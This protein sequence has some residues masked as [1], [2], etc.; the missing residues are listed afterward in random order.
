MPTYIY[1][2]PE[3]GHTTTLS[4][5]IATWRGLGPLRCRDCDVEKRLVIGAPALSSR[6]RT[7]GKS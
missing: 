7:E 3:C 1:R 6:R 5:S 4:V 2:C